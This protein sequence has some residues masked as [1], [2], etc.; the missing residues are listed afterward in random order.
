MNKDLLAFT[1]PMTSA[2]RASDFGVLIDTTTIMP[3]GGLPTRRAL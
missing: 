1:Q 3:D 2:P